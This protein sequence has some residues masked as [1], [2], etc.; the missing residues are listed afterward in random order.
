MNREQ[1]VNKILDVIEDNKSLHCLLTDYGE[2]IADICE[3]YAKEQVVE[4]LL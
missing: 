3:E 4:K 1:L 2:K